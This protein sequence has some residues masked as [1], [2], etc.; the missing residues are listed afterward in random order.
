MKG[1]EKQSFKKIIYSKILPHLKSL[2][3]DILDQGTDL[4]MDGV[5]VFKAGDFFVPGKIVNGVSYVVTME[6]DENKQ[7]WLD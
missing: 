6:A 7:V 5:E 3:N 4:M 2:T 1:Y